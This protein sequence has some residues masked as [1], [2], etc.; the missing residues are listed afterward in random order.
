MA[1]Q[2]PPEIANP[3]KDLLQQDAQPVLDTF[4]SDI[5]AAGNKLVSNL[6]Q[7]AQAPASLGWSLLT[8]IAAIAAHGELAV[9]LKH[10]Q[11]SGS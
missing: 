10:N 3:L 5:Q 4:I 11:P 6:P 9:I 8:S 2:L 7:A 1:Y